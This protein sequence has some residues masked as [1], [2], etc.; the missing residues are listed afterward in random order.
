MH[1]KLAEVKIKALAENGF[2]DEE[3]LLREDSSQESDIDEFLNEMSKSKDENMIKVANE[4]KNNFQKNRSIY[5]HKD[6]NI[7]GIANWPHDL[8]AGIMNLLTEIQDRKRL[9]NSI[10][11]S[12]DGTIGVI[13]MVN[14]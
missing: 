6:P 10:C 1:K 3:N 2:F 5:C 9:L 12:G 4:L 14:H 13:D 8:C 11:D 7:R